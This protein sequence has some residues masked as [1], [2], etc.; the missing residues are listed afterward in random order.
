MGAGFGNSLAGDWVVLS[1]VLAVTGA[2]VLAFLALRRAARVQSQASRRIAE[3]ETRL[4]EAETALA[5]EA[6]LLLIWRGRETMPAHQ[7]RC[8]S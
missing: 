7:R 5:A 6:H 2:F 8:G 4:N 1:A 3:L